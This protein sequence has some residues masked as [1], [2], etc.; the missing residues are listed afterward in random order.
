MSNEI[1]A[2]YS[3][4]GLRERIENGLAKLGTTP[5][6]ASL[7]PVDEF[8]VG[9]R[10]ATAHL[11]DRLEL[12]A[13]DRVLDI[14]CGLGGT[15]R[16]IA[17]ATGA[18]VTGVDLTRE[19][20]DVAAWLTQLVG[21]DARATFVHASAADMPRAAQP[22]TAATM[23]HVGMNI[24]DKEVLFADVAAQL[25]PSARF[26]IYDLMVTGAAEP[27]YPVPWAASS[28]TSALETAAA[29]QANLRATGFEIEVVEDRTEAALAGFEQLASSAS[30]GLPPLGLHLVMGP[31][32]STK[33]GNLAAAVRNGIIAPTEIIAR[34]S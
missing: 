30:D 26:A 31:T 15:A 12:G 22:F 24:P 28:A 17:S 10:P 1:A 23:V 16:Y 25:A 7:G 4:G 2:H 14:G 8:H 18:K 19:Y 20:I 34:R 32:T 33:F 21:L 29:Y 13:S 9:G 3:F 27:E 11:I 5:T 6:V